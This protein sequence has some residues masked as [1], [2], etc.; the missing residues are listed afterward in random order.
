MAK[1]YLPPIPCDLFI[2]I[3]FS[4]NDGAHFGLPSQLKNVDWF[5]YTCIY[6]WPVQ[7]IW[8]LKKNA[9]S[10]AVASSATAD[11]VCCHRSG[12]RKLLA[13]ATNKGH[14]KLYNYPVLS[15]GSKFRTETGHAGDVSSC[16][17]SIDDETLVTIGKN[18]RTILVWKVNRKI[19]GDKSKE[20][21]A[22][23]EKKE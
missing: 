14:V 23:E 2:F 21:D 8:P 22:D 15:K 20:S 13:T 19:G 5:T 10:L 6:G 12:D 9:E 4:Q 11:P 7:G 3:F 17:F 16:R 1:F 18:D